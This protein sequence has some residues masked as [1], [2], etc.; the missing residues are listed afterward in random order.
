[1][2]FSEVIQLAKSVTLGLWFGKPAQMLWAWELLEKVVT[3][4]TVA[5]KKTHFLIDSVIMILSF[6]KI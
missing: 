3:E 6:C 4:I 1:M 2:A 5:V